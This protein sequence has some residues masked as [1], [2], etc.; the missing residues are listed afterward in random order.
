M[1]ATSAAANFEAVCQNINQLSLQFNRQSPPKL[2]VV[3]KTQPIDSILEVYRC[4]H[5]NFGENYVRELIAK[6]S[7]LPGDI[8][9][10]FIGHLQSNKCKSLLGIPNLERISSVDS[11]NLANKLEV[12]CLE[13]SRTVDVLVQ[14]GATGEDTKTGT[15]TEMNVCVLL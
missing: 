1:A 5:R 3:T 12:T 9:W 10:H 13:S 4:G 11:V 2:L 7:L 15:M 6:A 8:E 14:V